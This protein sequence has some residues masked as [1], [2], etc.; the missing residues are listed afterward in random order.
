M[1]NKNIIFALV[2]IAISVCYTSAAKAQRIVSDELIAFWT[3][4][5]SDIEGETAKDVLGDSDGTI[6]G[7][8]RVVNGKIEEALEFDGVSNYIDL[9][10]ARDLDLP[11]VTAECWFK[12]SSGSE[13]RLFAPGSAFA[14]KWFLILNEG[15]N[16]VVSRT[17][18]EN[19]NQQT[20]NSFND[21]QWHHVV[22][23]SAARASDIRIYVDGEL[24]PSDPVA[25]GWSLNGDCKIGAKGD[26][27]YM[28]SGI[29]DEFRIYN[30]AL[31]EDEV[32][33]NYRATSQF[34][35]VE[36]ASKL[37]ITWG[38]MKKLASILACEKYSQD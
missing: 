32:K 5:S 29:I 17:T 20:T 27:Q 3:L 11:I 18:G 36:P 16:I 4:D 13:M 26:A 15:G 1:F 38:K 31:T 6:L 9:G 7:V 28:F 30:R 2:V 24:E 10:N 19:Q 37:V 12:T 35:A 21:D 25:E 8:P 22:G 34:I 14:N 33:Q 23:I